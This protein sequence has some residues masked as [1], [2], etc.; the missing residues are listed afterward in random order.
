MIRF[1]CPECGKSLKADDDAAGKSA[2]C[3]RCGTKVAIP[4]ATA[5]SAAAPPVATLPAAPPAAAAHADDDEPL[6]ELPAAHGPEDLIDM[7]AMVD[8]VFFLLI[9][10]LVTSLQ[11]VLAVM[12]LP[13]PQ[14][15][16]GTANARSSVADFDI[17]VRIEEDD[18]IWVEEQQAFNDQELRVRLRGAAD[19]TGHPPTVLVMGNADASTLA[20]VRVFDACAYAKVKSIAFVVQEGDEEK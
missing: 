16:T 10:F 17:Q 14:A 13:T 20:A 9:F 8:I 2:V 6:L 7:T 18:S 11:A 12:N 5:E 1:S 19:Q 3:S 15:A 4:A